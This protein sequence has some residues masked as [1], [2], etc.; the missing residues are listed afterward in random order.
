MGFPVA[1]A[2]N[3]TGFPTDAIV[4]LDPIDCS[5]GCCGGTIC[6]AAALS[7]VRAVPAGFAVARLSIDDA[8][9]VGAGT[10]AAAGGTA[11]ISLKLSTCAVHVFP[12]QSKNEVLVLY[13]LM[14]SVC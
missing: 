10:A 5:A 8:S 14:S 13:C 1:P 9:D 3:A 6:G 12:K 2:V 4:E 11:T 7:V